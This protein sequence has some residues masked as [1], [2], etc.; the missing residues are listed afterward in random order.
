MWTSI[1]AGRGGGPP[2][3]DRRWSCSR[4]LTSTSAAP[5]LRRRVA[6]NRPDAPATPAA[7][8][9]TLS[10]DL[11]RALHR[12][13]T[14]DPEERD[15]DCRWC[16]AG[17][18]PGPSGVRSRR[19]SIVQPTR[20]SASQH[21]VEFDDGVGRRLRPQPIGGRPGAPLARRRPRSPRRRRRSAGTAIA[22]ERR[23]RRA[24]RR[25]RAPCRMIRR[26]DSG[27]PP[28]SRGTSL[29]VACAAC[30]SPKSWPSCR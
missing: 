10:G 16:R 18:R 6:L 20:S 15:P 17:P 23:V 29:G 12:R 5:G 22:S 11:V 21:V 7:P 26:R 30:C 27:D 3:R 14:V 9:G 19:A 8:R 4:C 13:R 1:I 24:M 25:H 28:R 2:R